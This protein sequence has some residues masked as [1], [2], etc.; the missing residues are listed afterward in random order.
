MEDGME[1]GSEDDKKKKNLDDISNDKLIQQAKKGD[2]T[3]RKAKAQ[4]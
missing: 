3:K 4:K 2:G 1:D